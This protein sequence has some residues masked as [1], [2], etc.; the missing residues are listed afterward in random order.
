M[1]ECK[2]QEII[3]KLQ[4]DLAVAQSNI[5]AVKDDIKAM[6]E[7]IKRFNYYIIGG[8]A[9]SVLTLVGIIVQIVKG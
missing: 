4:L 5:Q 2:Y 8:L 7:D 3:H 9:S 6:K 1:H